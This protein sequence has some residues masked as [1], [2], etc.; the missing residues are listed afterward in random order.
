MSKPI[1]NADVGSTVIVCFVNEDGSPLWVRGNVARIEEAFIVV[2]MRT[3]T[4]SSMLVPALRSNVERFRDPEPDGSR[5]DP[6]PHLREG[7][8]ERRPW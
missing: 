4:G 2:A 7:L 6:Y 8:T 3:P 1:T 5:E